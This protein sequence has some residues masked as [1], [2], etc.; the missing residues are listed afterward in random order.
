VC[1]PPSDCAN[2]AEQG[3]LADVDDPNIALAARAAYRERQRHLYNE[4][5]A[6]RDCRYFSFDAMGDALY[7]ALAPQPLATRLES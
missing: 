7:G 1:V 2:S 3:G 5:N 4:E 6:G